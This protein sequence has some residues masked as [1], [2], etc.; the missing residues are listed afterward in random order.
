M[1]Q[2]TRAR[3]S[4]CFWV[5]N[6]HTALTRRAV[7][8]S[9][10]SR[11]RRSGSQANPAVFSEESIPMTHWAA[12]HATNRG[13]HSGEAAQPT[14]ESRLAVDGC[15]PCF[16]PFVVDLGLDKGKFRCEGKGRGLGL[17]TCRNSA[18]TAAVCCWK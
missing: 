10:G 9:P 11:R 15:L 14:T 5:P 12:V 2:K 4:D 17:A 6:T 3:E 16:P 8:P 1:L 7:N 18:A 13:Y